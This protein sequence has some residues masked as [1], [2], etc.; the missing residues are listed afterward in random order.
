MAQY[1]KVELHNAVYQFQLLSGKT[2]L[3][4]VYGSKPCCIAENGY[5]LG[6]N[7]ACEKFDITVGEPLSEALLKCADLYVEAPHYGLLRRGAALFADICS[8]FGTVRTAAFDTCLLETGELPPTDVHVFADALVGAIEEELH[9]VADI[10]TVT[11][12]DTS[13]NPYCAAVH[14]P[15]SSLE[16]LAEQLSLRLGIEQASARLFSMETLDAD[17][18]LHRADRRV[19]VPCSDFAMVHF[20]LRNMVDLTLQATCISV[21]LY[22]VFITPKEAPPALSVKEKKRTDAPWN[23]QAQSKRLTDILN[24]NELYVFAKLTAYLS[25]NPLSLSFDELCA[26]A[27]KA[28]TRRLKLGN[29]YINPDY[30]ER[31]VEKCDA[32]QTD[33]PRVLINGY[34]PFALLFLL[35]KTCRAE[36]YYANLDERTLE[37]L[38]LL[39]PLSPCAPLDMRKAEEGTYDIAISGSVPLPYA[40]DT[41]ILLVKKTFFSEDSRKEIQGCRISDIFD[42]GTYGFGGAT[43]QYAALIVRRGEQP[44]ITVL[45]SLDDGCTVEQRQ[46]YITDNSLPCWVIYRN[47]RFDRVYGKLQFGVFDVQCSMQIKQRDYNAGGDICVVSAACIDGDGSVHLDDGCRHV[48]SSDISKYEIAAYAERDDVFFAAARSSVLKV[49]RKPKGCVPN[50]STVL[51]IPKKDVTITGEDVAY[52]LTDEFRYFYTIALN[53]RKFLLSTDYLSQYFLGKVVS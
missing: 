23:Y 4:K 34:C 39:D 30:A 25:E 27:E 53:H 2:G 18:V 33:K 19:E 14:L 45:H 43:E 50:P 24:K 17:G 6:V 3:K 48:A 37:V 41:E 29:Q 9:A 13:L 26:L 38:G 49:A 8:R 44:H 46:E 15:A 47:E 21:N 28:N 5:I 22:D 31:F 35:K 42:F 7:N 10:R 11:E 12:A 32:L 51:L 1:F 52:Y 40:A 36:L 20:V 16:Y